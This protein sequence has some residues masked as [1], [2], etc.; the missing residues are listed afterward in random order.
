M[1]SPYRFSLLALPLLTAG[2]AGFSI[3]QSTTELNRQFPQQ[4]QGELQLARD[5]SQAQALRQQADALLMAPLSQHDAVRLALWNSPAIQSWLAQHW[6]DGARLAQQG[7]IANPLLNL[8]RSQLAGE[9]EIARSLSLGLLDLLSLPRRQ[10]VSVAQLQQAQLQFSQQVL[11]HITQ[12]RLAWIRAVAAQ[13]SLEYAQQVN[14]AAEAGAELARR[15]RTAGN[16]SALQSARQQSFSADATARLAQARQAQLASREALVRLL[17]LNA[18]Q[19]QLLQLPAHLPDLPAQPLA[20]EQVASQLPQN[21]LDVRIAA[22]ALQTAAQRQG[23]QLLQG[24]TDIELSVKRDTV[25]AAATDG[26]AAGRVKRGLG[27]SISLPFFDQG[28]LQRDAM[29]ADTLAASY[30]LENSLRQA[31]SQLRESYAVYHSNYEIARHHRDVVL[32]LKRQIAEQNTLRYNGMLISVFELLGSSREQIEG[33]LATIQ[34][35]QQFWIAD[36]EL[37]ASLLGAASP[38]VLRPASLVATPSEVAH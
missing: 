14:E 4:T 24:W 22:A 1:F 17:G 16:F 38:T 26:A 9:L 15:M 35:N 25:F 37:Q 29:R 33:V 2:C 3:D 20:A 10:Q 12:L 23:L 21:R 6:G 31:A 36:A 19:A 34:A 11:Q 5:S 8:E 7:R 13:Q 32:P 30:Q 27:L 28:Q 18:E